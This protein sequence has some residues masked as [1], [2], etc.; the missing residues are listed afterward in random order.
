M[1]CVTRP[2]ALAIARI[3]RTAAAG[4]HEGPS[5]TRTMAGAA[6]PAKIAPGIMRIVTPPS[7]WL[8]AVRTR[9]REDCTR[10]I[11]GYNTPVNAIVAL[12]AGRLNSNVAREY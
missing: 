5:T 6:T 12:Y 2:S 9:S 10:A 1:R 4:P 7:A 11:A 3:G 8:S